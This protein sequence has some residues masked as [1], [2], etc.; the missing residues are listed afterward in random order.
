MATKK[1]PAKGKK[2]RSKKQHT[3]DYYPVQRK[4]D[5]SVA[6]G[7]FNGTLVG[8]TGRLLSQVNRRLY[9]YGKMYQN[10]IDFDVPSNLAAEAVVEVYA[11]A[12][13]WD[14][15]RAYAL[16]KKVYDEAYTDERNMSTGQSARWSDFRVGSGVTGGINMVPQT[17]DNATLA[18]S[19]LNV[20][21]H[22]QSSVDKGGV[23]TYFTWG[24]ATANQIDIVN[25]WIESGRV[26]ATPS[27]LSTT[28]PYEGV[29][30]D[31]L[32]NLEQE[33]LADH[34]NNPPYSTNA[35]SDQLVKVA[36]IYFRPGAIGLSKLSTGFFDAPCGLFVL[37]TNLALPT[38]SVTLTVKSGDYKGVHALSMC[39]E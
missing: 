31:Q 17:Y 14:V 25:E 28:A 10:K 34:G 38:G 26:S 7:S 22:D 30:S 6:S 5:L 39:Q 23:E 37:K 1:A 29:N 3:P 13:T 8:D 32:S 12:N 9:R 11:L 35:D 20:G 36:T 27:T 24:A 16:A 18:A 4:I 19:V 21:E 2:L 15:Q 33:H